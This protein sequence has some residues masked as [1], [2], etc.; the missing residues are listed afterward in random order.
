M[1]ISTRRQSGP[2]ERCRFLTLNAQ[3][4]EIEAEVMEALREVCASQNFILG[5]R[6]KELEE[7]VAE[8]SQC[9]YG[10]GVSSGTDALLVALM[11]SGSRPR[12]RGDHHSHLPFLRQRGVI[13]RLGARPLFCDIDPVTYN[14]SAA[15]VADLIA[16]QCEFRDGRLHQPEN[17]RCCQ[18]LDAGA[19]FWADGRYGS[20]H[21]AGA[22]QQPQSRRRCGSGH[23]FRISGGRRAGSM[24]D[25]GCFSFFPSKNLG[26][27]GDGGNVRDQ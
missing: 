9:R 14:L 10:I 7:R 18:S 13:S 19:P 22:A 4:R 12:R 11:S 15:R 1:K 5:A 23:R 17:R 3:Y 25:I 27:F 6:V 20:A 26:A 2:I 8:Y 21:G 16:T 24:G